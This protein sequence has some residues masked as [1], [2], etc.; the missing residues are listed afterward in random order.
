MKAES[1][2]GDDGFGAAIAEQPIFWLG[3]VGFA[4]DQR[5]AIE[6]ALTRVAAL[7]QWRLAPFRESDAWFVNGAKCRLVP[8]GNLRVAPGMPNELSVNLDLGGVDRPVAFADPLAATDL[9]PRHRFDAASPGGVQGVLLQFDGWLRF[10]RAQFVL[11]RQVVQLG[12]R[13][14]HGIFHIASRSKL[15]AVLDFRH[16]QAALAPQLQPG[17]LR[18]AEWA[19]RPEGAAVLPEQF[20]V[21]STAQLAWSYV[22]RTERDLLPAR[23]RELAVHYR[24]KPR[25]PLRWL[26]DSQLMLL[27]ELAAES[28]TVPELCQRTGLATEQVER[29]LSCLYYAAAVTTTQS[30]A[31]PRVG[32]AGIEDSLASSSLQ[33]RAPDGEPSPVPFRSDLTVPAILRA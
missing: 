32:G 14:R 21:C 29:D 27:K 13:L 17:D 31:A 5:T 33:T 8:G 10:A 18:D 11:G 4:P 20:L 7:P 2:S 24:G 1:L 6:S 26:R 23:Y 9:E 3:L 28:A 30:K 12:A 15:L 19:K 25:V 16:G 22:R